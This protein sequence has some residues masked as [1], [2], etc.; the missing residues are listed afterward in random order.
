MGRVKIRLLQDKMARCWV[1]AMVN[2]EQCGKGIVLLTF[3]VS[4]FHDTDADFLNLMAS[5]YPKIYV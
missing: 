3:L 4:Y 1:G 2:N 5:P